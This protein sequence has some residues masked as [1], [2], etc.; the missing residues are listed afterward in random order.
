MSLVRQLDPRLKVV[1]EQRSRRGGREGTQGRESLIGISQNTN[2]CQ[3]EPSSSSQCWSLLPVEEKHFL[4]FNWLS[5]FH[6]KMQIIRAASITYGEFISSLSNIY[7][8]T[9]NGQGLKSY[10]VNCSQQKSMLN[11][12][13]PPIIVAGPDRTTDAWTKLWIYSK[14]KS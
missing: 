4:H 5:L 10:S 6:S 3:G 13:L 11:Q 9:S 14:D 2:H 7:F 8:T 1:D 12:N